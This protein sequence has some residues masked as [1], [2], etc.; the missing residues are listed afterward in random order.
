MYE[1]F[2]PV[3]A[4]LN[5][6]LVQ[7]LSADELAVLDKALLAIQSEAEKMLDDD[8]LPKANRR[9]NGNRD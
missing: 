4:E 8:A 1:S 7:S 3:V 5:H 9:R 2:F 6:R